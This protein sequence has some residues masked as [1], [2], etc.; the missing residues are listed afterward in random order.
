MVCY[1]V[2][3]VCAS[4]D[5]LGVRARLKQHIL[6]SP[7][8]AGKCRGLDPLHNYCTVLYI[9]GTGADCKYSTALTG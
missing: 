8:L 4:A 2:V 3:F 7:W 5:F 9:T 1:W 6:M